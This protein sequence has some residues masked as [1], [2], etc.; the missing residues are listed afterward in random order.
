VEVALKTATLAQQVAGRPERCGVLAF[1]GGYHG[2][3]YGALAVTAYK[4]DFR[5]PFGPQLNPHV[6]HLPFGCPP[7]AISAFIGG[8]ASGGEAIGAVLVEPIQG[9]GGEVVAPP[10]WLR[11]LRGLCDDHGLTL[12]FDEIY[13]GLGRT[14]RWWAADEEGVVP[15]ILAVGKALGGGLP[16]GACVARAE[17]MAAWG[18]SQ[19]E[20]IHTSTFLGHPIAAACAVSALEALRSLDIPARARAFEEAVRAFFGPLGVPV[21]GRGAMVGLELGSPGRAARVTGALLKAG[22]IV[23]PSGIDGDIL[24]LTPPLVLTEIQRQAAFEAIATALAEVT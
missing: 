23:L 10:G 24:A 8:V 6:R 4:R 19:G 14:G 3:S 2:L 5:R 21:R 11:A 17:V 9:R 20:A 15:D 7:E 16:I 13:S 12:V 22:Y 1:S 18:A